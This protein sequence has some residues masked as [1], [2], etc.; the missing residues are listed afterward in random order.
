MQT[1]RLRSSLLEILNRFSVQ[2]GW[3][4]RG[5]AHTR[6]LVGQLLRAGVFNKDAG[7]FLRLLAA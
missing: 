5:E 6:S 4:G 2:P 1:C 3:I 7:W